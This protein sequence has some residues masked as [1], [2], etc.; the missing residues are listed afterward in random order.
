[1][2]RILLLLLAVVFIYPTA[3]AQP[4]V[5]KKI[6][7]SGNVIDSVSKRAIEYPTVALF[8]DSLVLIKSVAGGADGKFY[9]D[10]EPGNYVLVA[11]MI[12][13]S[14]HRSK[15]TIDG[16]KSS[17]SVGDIPLVEGVQLKGVTVTGVKPLIKSEPDK[18]TYNIDADPQAVS[19]T[20]QDILR[21]VPMLSVDGDGEVR[22]N[23]EKNYKVLVNG[24][25]SGVLV[26]NF[27][28]V[29]KSMP[30]NSIKSVEVITNPP[31][32][33]E[34]EG[35]SG[36][37]NIITN[38]RNDRGYNG[39]ISLGSSTLGG[40]KANG[41]IAAQVGKFALSGN[42]M[43]G[44][45][46][47]PDSYSNTSV[48]NNLS[49]N[50]HKSYSNTTS[51]DKN[52]M[53]LFSI[54]ASYEIDSLNL[55]T[56][57]GSG[58]FGDY[59]TNSSMLYESMNR[60]G[61]ASRRYRQYQDAT[62][63]YGSGSGSISYQK[64]YK[65][66]QKNLTISYSIDHNPSSRENNSTIIP[67]LDFYPLEKYVKNEAHSTEHAF[68]VDYY[69]PL[70]NSHQLETGA[71][72]I[73]RSNISETTGAPEDIND[74]DYDQHVFNVYAGYL[75]KKTKHILKGGLRGEYTYNDGLSKHFDGDTPFSNRQM[76]IV[77]YVNYTYM[78]NKARTYTISYT[79][80]LNRPGIM[81]LNPYVDKSNP[82]FINFGN[83]N[84]KSVKR[85]AFALSY[86]R[87][88]QRWNV[89]VNLSA[90]F[91][92]NNIEEI[93]TVDANGVQ[94]RTYDNIGKN[95]NYGLS[96]NYSYMYGSRFSI[97]SGV[98]VG[99][100]DISTSQSSKTNSGFT[101]N[102]N[103]N[104]NLFMWKGSSL[105]L[106]AFLFGG[107]I[108]LQS[109][110]GT[111]FMNYFGFNQRLFND[112][113]TLSVNATSPF[114]KM[115]DFSYDS[116]DENYTMSASSSREARRISFGLS[117]RFGKY[118]AVVKKARKS[119]I[120]DKMGGGAQGAPA[121]GGATTVPAS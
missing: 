74:L 29:I 93:V 91:T 114:K 109:K 76:D 53:N 46:I 73:Y 67:E 30:A 40:Y 100:S 75:Y 8:T 84:L 118:R 113:L 65:K 89:G 107:D 9:I 80:R 51:S 60:Q 38:T 37:I 101:Y 22:L 1:M 54:E 102:G 31:V 95:N 47:S 10:A 79:Q 68:Q 110:M 112:R 71:K 21:K 63:G 96:V 81:Y 99:Y 36:I 26:K 41:F 19:S 61:V 83:P 105:S 62:Y 57:S 111:I 2:N 117:W 103:L 23:G 49:D 92:T 116:S 78:G 77:P 85:H 24:R 16:D 11:S 119:A 50:Y 15:I 27:K 34:A 59:N 87:A 7:I 64:S 39:S 12:G 14:N 86:R 56:L 106:G 35:V 20:I 5:S 3:K 43:N 70:K 108:S 48:I 18:L 82:M 44:R 33:Y 55:L 6:T 17:F 94:Y 90:N 97:N 13:Y 72:Y 45:E 69:D 42:F 28:E 4:R 98:R 120:D 88:S 32:K 58:F 115:M 121:G 52:K 66:P 25:S 104:A